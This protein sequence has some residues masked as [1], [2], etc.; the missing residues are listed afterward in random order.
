MKKEKLEKL[1][2]S[3]CGCEIILRAED[4]RYLERAEKEINRIFQKEFAVPNERELE[5]IVERDLG[6]KKHWLFGWIK[7]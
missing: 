5:K 3:F 4:T 6:V 1:I 7:D 2:M